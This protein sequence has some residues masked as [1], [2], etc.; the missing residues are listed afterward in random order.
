MSLHRFIKILKPLRIKKKPQ[1]FVH[2]P[3]VIYLVAKLIKNENKIF[4]RATCR[5]QLNKISKFS[6]DEAM[7]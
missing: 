7:Y 2:N 4:K 5:K 6:T 3:L 1:Y